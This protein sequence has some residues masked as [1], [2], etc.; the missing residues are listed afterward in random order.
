MIYSIVLEADSPGFGLQLH[1]L[2]LRDLGN[3]LNPSEPWTLHLKMW[4]YFAKLL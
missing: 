3:L 2:P 1:S 4:L